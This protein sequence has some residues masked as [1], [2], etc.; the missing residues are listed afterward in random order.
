MPKVNIWVRKQ[1]MPIYQKID[2]FPQWLHDS[3][4][5]QLAA[6]EGE[7]QNEVNQQ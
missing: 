6:W 2:D 4:Q 5:Q 7:Y 1:D 3:F